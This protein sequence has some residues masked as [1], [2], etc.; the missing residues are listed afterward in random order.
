MTK[1]PR[2]G[3]GYWIRWRGRETARKAASWRSGRSVT[4][5]RGGM[6]IQAFGGALGIV[7][8]GSAPCIRCVRIR[9]CWDE[10]FPGLCGGRSEGC[11]GAVVPFDPHAPDPS[12]HL[13]PSPPLPPPFLR[14]WGPPFTEVLPKPG[15]QQ[16]DMFVSYCFCSCSIR[17]G[18]VVAALYRRFRGR[19]GAP[20][21]TPWSPAAIARTP[22][23][24][25]P[26]PQAAQFRPASSRRLSTLSALSAPDSP[27]PP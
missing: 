25:S 6:P 18:M 13:H 4:T 12:R 16:F 19:P 7:S 27:C 14:C 17:L 22:F 8:A 21:A 11:C 5:A 10:A 23:S 1:Q 24:P 3:V 20:G 9:S 26:S 15:A 2:A